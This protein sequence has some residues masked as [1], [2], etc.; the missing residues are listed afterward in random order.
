MAEKWKP[1]VLGCEHSATMVQDERAQSLLDSG[2]SV[3]IPI[4]C[5]SIHPVCF[6]LLGRR[7]S[8]ICRLWW[9]AYPPD[10]PSPPVMASQSQSPVSPE[11]GM[12][13][14]WHPLEAYLEIL[15]FGHEFMNVGCGPQ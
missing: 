9:T 1:G 10:G 8:S 7:P 5:L 3:N 14:G 4:Y 6:L 13:H 15:I 12:R 11:V 2:I